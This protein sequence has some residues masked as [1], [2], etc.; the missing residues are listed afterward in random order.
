MTVPPFRP[1]GGEDIRVVSDVSR[2]DYGETD[3]KIR[4]RNT[5][6]T[7]PVEDIDDTVSS[8][9]L[10]LDTIIPLYST[11]INEGNK[12]SRLKQQ[13][14]NTSRQHDSPPKEEITPEP[15]YLPKRDM[16]KTKKVRNKYSFAVQ[17]IGRAHV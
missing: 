2:F 4:S 12:Y 3:Q 9:K 16:T 6:P 14:D 8:S 13:D 1:Y 17:E 10:T 15:I 7:R 5:T 11:K